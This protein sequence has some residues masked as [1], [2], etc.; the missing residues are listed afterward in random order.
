MSNYNYLTMIILRRC[1]A[2]YGE[3]TSLINNGWHERIG[4]PEY[5]TL[6]DAVI[7]RIRPNA[8][9]VLIEGAVSMRE[10]RGVK[11]SGAGEA[12]DGDAV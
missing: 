9:E 5:E 1:R 6:C 10:R 12:G 7:D 2:N 8:Y 4:S 11:A 3:L